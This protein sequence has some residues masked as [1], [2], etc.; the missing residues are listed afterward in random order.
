MLYTTLVLK[1]VRYTDMLICVN[2]AISIAIYEGNKIEQNVLPAVLSFQTGRA[3]LMDFFCY[4]L[5]RNRT[6]VHTI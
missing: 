2:K 3:K 6:F 1:I 5:Q 4:P